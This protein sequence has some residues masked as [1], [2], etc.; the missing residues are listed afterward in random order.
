LK[1]SSTSPALGSTSIS[2]S[3]QIVAS[4]AFASRKARFRPGQK[5]GPAP[6]ASDFGAA[7]S[8]LSSS[9]RCG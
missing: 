1:A 2:K 3:R 9:Q 4:A 5:R 7:L 8:S 6:K